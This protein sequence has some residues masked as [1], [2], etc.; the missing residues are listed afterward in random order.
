M[1]HI[2]ALSEV[3]HLCESTRQCEEYRTTLQRE[4]QQIDAY[5]A[6]TVQSTVTSGGLVA[7]IG[8]IVLLTPFFKPFQK[9]QKFL[10]PKLVI[11]APIVIGLAAGAGVGFFI[12]FKACF[13][14]EC[15][16]IEESAIFTIPLLT[17][18]LTVPLAKIIYLKRQ[19]MTDA[20][21]KTKP[22]IW[23][24]L[25][26]IIIALAIIFTTSSISEDRGNGESKKQYLRNAES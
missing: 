5:T 7:V 10:L 11:A 4:D 15:S 1:S 2:Q 8:V 26:I 19:P 12:S 21:S 9:F 6:N 3:K 17:L 18:I 24:V 23:A 16:A 22:Y 25:G 13:F 14:T 20:I